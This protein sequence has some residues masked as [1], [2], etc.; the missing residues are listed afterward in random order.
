MR[1]S[2]SIRKLA[3]TA[4]VVSSVG[5]VG[6][7]AVFLA[8]AIVAFA[9]EDIQFVRMACMAMGLT[10]W[11]VILPFS[12]ASFATGLVQALGTAWGLVRHYWVVVKLLLTT[13]ATAV[14]LLKLEPIQRLASAAA[15]LSFATNDL[16]DLKASLLVHAAAGLVLLLAITVLGI[17]KPAGLTH[18]GAATERKR[19]A[20]P[21]AL[22]LPSAGLPRWV[23]VCLVLAMVLVLL[24][25]VALLHGGHGPTAHLP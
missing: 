7:L 23:K 6:A 4:H 25:V 14:L 20:I 10:A 13:L 2:P 22:D 17:Y 8:H 12:L 15:D 19:N 21:I 3:L 18:R 1:M 16:P 24:S 11:Y 5:W 9:G